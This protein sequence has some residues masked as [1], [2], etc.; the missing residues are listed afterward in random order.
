MVET[1]ARFAGSARKNDCRRLDAACIV[2]DARDT[3]A[4]RSALRVISRAAAR[5]AACDLPGTEDW[6]PWSVD[7]WAKA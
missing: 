7:I 3:A 5:P 6:T 1:A 2:S 4:H